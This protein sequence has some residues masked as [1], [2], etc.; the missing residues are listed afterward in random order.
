[1]A[2]TVAAAFMV[3]LQVPVPEQPPPDQP[4][5]VEPALGAADNV[6]AGAGGVGLE[7]LLAPQAIPA[8]TRT[9]VPLPVPAL[10]TVRVKL[11]A[12]NAASTVVA[13]PMA[14]V[15][16]PCRSSRRRTSR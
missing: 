9:S 14:T 13:M 6:D 15:Q 12:L 4:V 10:A 11:W 8:G 16:V 2:V 3:T 7:Q 5:K 1:M